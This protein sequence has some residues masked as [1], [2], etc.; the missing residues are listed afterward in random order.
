[1]Q[2]DRPAAKIQRTDDR[3]ADVRC[4]ACD[5]LL[6]V[7]SRPGPSAPP[8]VRLDPIYREREKGF[9]AVA[10]R[11]PRRV[12]LHEY[13]APSPSEPGGYATLD[14]NIVRSCRVK[15]ATCGTINRVVM[16]N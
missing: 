12:R 8:L 10:K 11:P 16:P 7:A 15:C 3:R 6:G 4:I 5:R 13:R 14:D 1:M 2:P 9:F